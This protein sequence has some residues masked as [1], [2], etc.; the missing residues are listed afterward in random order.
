[1]PVGRSGGSAAG[2]RHANR[3]DLLE[4]KK[5]IRLAPSLDTAAIGEPQDSYAGPLATADST[6]RRDA[7]EL[8]EVRAEAREARHELVARLE[9][10]V[11]PQDDVRET[12]LPMQDI[13]VGNR[14]QQ[15]R[16]DLLRDEPSQQI[17]ASLIGCLVAVPQRAKRDCQIISGAANA[18]DVP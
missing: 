7:T 8:A 14:K 5:S 16:Q 1:V 18:Q 9:H 4:H 12:L 2:A 6:G 17:S 13:L 3:A 15:K 11:D 10:V